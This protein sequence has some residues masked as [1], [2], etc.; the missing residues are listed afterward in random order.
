MIK[1]VEVN[2]SIMDIQNPG[3]ITLEAVKAAAV[4]LDASLANAV[5]YEDGE[6]VRFRINAGT[7]GVDLKTVEFNGQ[8]INLGGADSNDPKAIQRAITKIDGSMANAQYE[9]VGDN[10]RFFINAGTKG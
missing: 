5:A 8:I 4:K 6:T 10:I 7:K 3:Q 2:G 1:Y 9:I